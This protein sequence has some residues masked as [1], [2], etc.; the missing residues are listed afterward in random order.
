MAGSGYVFLV[1]YRLTQ[2]QKHLFRAQKFAEF[3]DT[4]TFKNGAR[5]PDCPLS[6]YEGLAGTLC[7]LVDLA[8]PMQSHFPFSEVF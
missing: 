4:E 8:H 3:L 1:L 6:L 7:F 2:D 5:Q